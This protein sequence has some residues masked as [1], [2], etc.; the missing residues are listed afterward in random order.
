MR[1]NGVGISAPP[2]RVPSERRAPP[3]LVIVF[4]D[5]FLR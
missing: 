2:E 5:S 3:A 4:I 1:K